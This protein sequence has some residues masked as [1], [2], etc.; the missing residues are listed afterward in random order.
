MSQTSELETRQ[1][2][3]RLDPE[4][5]TITGLAVPYNQ[6]ANIGGRY[7]ERFAP[8]AISSVEDVKL[9]YQHAEPIGRVTTGADTPDGYRS[10]HRFQT[11]L[12]VMR[13]TLCS[14]MV[15]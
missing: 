10:L 6:D 14:A 13:F 5:R 11:R 3:V 1:F 2:E 8:G 12:E 7:T 9:F 4:T 15:Y